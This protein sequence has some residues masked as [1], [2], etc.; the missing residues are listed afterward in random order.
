MKILFCPLNWGLGHATRCVPLIQNYISEGHEVVLVSDGYPMEFLKLRFPDLRIIEYKSY[1]VRYSKTN[2]QV[3]AMLKNLPLVIS[4][5]FAE[6]QWLKKLLKREAFDVVVSDNRFGMWSKQTYSIYI[7]HQLMIKMPRW[8]FWLEPLAWLA[9]RFVISRYNVCYIPDNEDSDNLSGDLS[10]KYPL[11]RNAR[12][13][14][15]L[16][17]FSGF[18]NYKPDERYDVLAIVSGPEPQ[19]TLFANQLIERYKSGNEK[20]LLVCGTP[21]NQPASSILGNI[22]MVSHLTDYEFV[23][24]IAGVKK[25]ISRPG[26]SSLMDFK[27]LNCLPKVE[28]IPTPGQTEQEYLF[29]YQ[30]YR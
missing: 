4:G 3:F 16:S 1:S 9:H 14:G 17:R 30:N 29:E 27:V 12:F 15:Y 7:T 24:I 13:I 10:H 28:F 21:N 6:H 23:T 22:C 5:A 18:N 19:R 25:I 11:S 2:S 8:L 20:V 26:Y